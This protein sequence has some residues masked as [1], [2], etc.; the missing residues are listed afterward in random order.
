MCPS[1]RHQGPRSICGWASEGCPLFI[2]QETDP[3]SR[4]HHGHS[5]P[6]GLWSLCFPSVQRA[7]C[8]RLQRRLPLHSELAQHPGACE[9]GDPPHPVTHPQALRIRGRSCVVPGTGWR[10]VGGMPHVCDHPQPVLGSGADVPASMITNPGLRPLLVDR[11]SSNCE[12]KA[13]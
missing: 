3:S 5:R 1:G 12:G 11:S 4:S 7:R 9:S 6:E 13:T 2:A 10:W 8:A